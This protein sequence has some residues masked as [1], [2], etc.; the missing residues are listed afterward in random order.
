MHKQRTLTCLRLEGSRAEH[1][2]FP[3]IRTKRWQGVVERTGCRLLR[4]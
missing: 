4:S 2:V 3:R 1:M